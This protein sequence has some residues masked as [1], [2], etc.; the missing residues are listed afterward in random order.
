[1]DFLYSNVSKSKQCRRWSTLF[2]LSDQGLH[3]LPVDPDQT[4]PLGA[5]WSATTLFAQA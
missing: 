3:C 5:V 2:K 4:A 1:M